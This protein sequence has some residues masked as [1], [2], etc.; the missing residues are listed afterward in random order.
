[1]LSLHGKIINHNL[2]TKRYDRPVSYLIM[3]L[4]I[5]FSKIQRGGGKPVKGFYQWVSF[6]EQRR[7]NSN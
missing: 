1:M 4:L 7:V 2:H 5:G 6:V 3:L